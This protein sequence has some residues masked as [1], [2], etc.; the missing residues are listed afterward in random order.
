MEAL[1]DHP[2]FGPRT[3][4][5]STVFGVTVLIPESL[6]QHFLSKKQSIPVSVQLLPSMEVLHLRVISLHESCRAV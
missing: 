6:P 3:S 1:Q 2:G 4:P 5:P